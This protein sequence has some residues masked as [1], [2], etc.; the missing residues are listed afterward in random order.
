M[1]SEVIELKDQFIVYEKEKN[2]KLKILE[3]I[4]DNLNKTMEQIEVVKEEKKIH[5][6]DVGL[7]EKSEESKI[8][9]I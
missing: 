3:N 9:L 7:D 8:I 2:E 6:I 1:P 4:N 5:D